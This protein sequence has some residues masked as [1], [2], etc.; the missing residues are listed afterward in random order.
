M[1]LNIGQSEFVKLAE[2][3]WKVAPIN[4]GTNVKITAGGVW[5]A[6][7]N[8]L[9]LKFTTTDIANTTLVFDGVTYTNEDFELVSD[10]TYIFYSKAM[11]PSEFGN[12]KVAQFKCGEDE[13]TISYCVNS[14]IYAKQSQETKMGDL[15]RA[16][17]NYGVSAVAYM[18]LQ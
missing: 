9:Y 3:E 10:N 2:E 17:Y 7:V 18:K 16:L 1:L 4:T 5:F 8:K 11:S 14:Y 6:N 15:A 12:K 13:S